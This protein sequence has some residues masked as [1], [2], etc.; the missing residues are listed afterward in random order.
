[1]SN[2]QCTVSG[3][4]SSA[5]GSGNTLTLALNVSFG[6]G[7]AGNKIAYLAARDAAQNNSG[8]QALGTWAVPGAAAG[9]PAVDSLDPARGAGSSQTFTFT[10]S[11]TK[12]A[13]DL[14]VVN[15]LIHNSLDGRNSCYLAYNRPANVLFLVN[16]SGTALLPGLTLNGSG[17]TNNS[18][19][20]VNGANSSFKA[21][22]KTLT[23]TLNLSFAATF[24]GNRVI[25]MAARDLAD[26]GNSGWQAMGSW[27]VQ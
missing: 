23:L 21:T 25:Y 26:T 14:G 3:P 20:T 15:I 6:V 9:S 24:S 27:T 4:G 8:W 16:D 5:N 12:G 7:F 22:G 19:C 10:F 11:D 13:S 2:S 18:Q 1:M 17:S